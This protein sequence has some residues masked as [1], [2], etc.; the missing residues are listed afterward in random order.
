[1]L[2]P[3]KRGRVYEIFP[4]SYTKKWFEF[5]ALL[6]ITNDELNRNFPNRVCIFFAS[7]DKSLNLWLILQNEDFVKELSHRL[8]LRHEICF[9]VFSYRKPGMFHSTTI[10]IKQTARIVQLPLF[11]T[12]FEPRGK[13]SFSKSLYFTNEI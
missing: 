13:K 3:S 10:L 6:H 7:T 11:L 9:S 1:M 8:F 12:L 5:N 4:Y 2:S